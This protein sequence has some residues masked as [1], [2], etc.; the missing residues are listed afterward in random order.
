MASGTPLADGRNESINLTAAVSGT[1]RIRVNAEGSTTGE[2]FLSTPTA[3]VGIAAAGS[4]LVNESCPP[5]NGQIDPGERVTVNLKLMNNGSAPTT[6]LVATLQS[7]G[8]V[9]APSGPQTFGTIA[10][11]AMAGRDFSFTADPSLTPG[12]TI[13]AT[14]Q[15]QD[16]ASNLGTVSFNFTAGPAPCGDV[17]L[18]VTSTLTRMSSTNVRAS[19]TVQNIGSTSAANVML[20][21]AKLGSTNGT[22]LPQSLGNIAPGGTAGGDVNFTNSSPGT[23]ST[24][25]LGGTYTGG[26]FTSTRRVTVP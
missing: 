5:A 22:P 8:G 26:T 14:L 17:R 24:L 11:G 2:Y 16:G 6:N 1:Y 21:T 9:V 19:Y 15:L 3:P 4:T 23:A 7:T 25:T 18:V 12:Q 20:T 10:P 13:T